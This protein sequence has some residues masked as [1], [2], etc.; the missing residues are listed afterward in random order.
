MTVLE[1]GLVSGNQADT[2]GLINQ[3]PTLKRFETKD[4][5]VILYF[6]KVSAC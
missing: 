1:V 5:K 6:D 4:R 2:S 3:V